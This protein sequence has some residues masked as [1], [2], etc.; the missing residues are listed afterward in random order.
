MPK[1]SQGFS[2]YR[3][4]AI[5]HYL[6]ETEGKDVLQ[7]S[8]PWT[9]VFFWILGALI[10]AAL[11]LSI[12]G[13][14]EVNDRGKGILRPTGGV[15]LMLAQNSGVIAELKARNGD[16]VDRGAPILRLES[17]QVQ[18]SL[19]EADRSLGLLTSEFGSVAAQQDALYARQSADVQ[20]RIASLNEDISSYKKSLELQNE[21]LK[22]NQELYKQNII[23]KLEVG[24]AEDQLEQSK[25]QL[26]N[27][28]V[29]LAQAEQE[30]VS[31]EATRRQQLFSRKSDLSGAQ[32][33]REALSFSLNQNLFL[34]P[35]RGYVDALVARVGDSVQPG[36]VIAKLVP[37]DSALRVIS[38]LPEK[39]RAFVKAGDIVQLELNQYP[40]AEFGTVRGRIVRVGE[41]LVSSHEWREAMGEERALEEAAFRVEVEL[42]PI[43]KGALAKVQLRPGMLMSVR[44][45]LRRQSLITLA[46]DPLKRWLN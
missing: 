24:A 2:L 10:V 7:I 15:R 17:P 27:A 32:T 46:L 30:R 26:R 16:F 9:W 43:T 13:K 20:K 42:L 19:L 1:P 33:K 35:D 34:A 6:Q 8:P 28:R 36:Q 14:V 18:A 39:N 29:Q 21:R 31:I 4:E 44:Y 22:A 3:Q 37:A 11:V 40:Y 12:V 45:T 41:D 5:E 25:R 23:G 38:F